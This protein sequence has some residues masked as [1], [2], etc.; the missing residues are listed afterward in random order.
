MP[1]HMTQNECC[2]TSASCVLSWSMVVYSFMA[3]RELRGEQPG[4]AARRQPAVVRELARHPQQE[5]RR[6]RRAEGLGR[7]PAAL[8]R[9]L[10]QLHLQAERPPPLSPLPRPPIAL[11]PALASA[12]SV[13]FHATR[14]GRRI[15]NEWFESIPDCSDRQA[16][17]PARQECR[18]RLALALRQDPP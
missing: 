11:F 12:S 3:H 14:T 8:D 5:A 10:L 13:A 18:S 6:E 9:G 17:R 4:A 15:R 7:Q 2:L 16:R 1:R